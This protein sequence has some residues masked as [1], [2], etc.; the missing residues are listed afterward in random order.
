MRVNPPSWL[1]LL[2]GPTRQSL[3]LSLIPQSRQCGTTTLRRQPKGSS[4]LARL[5][6]F[7]MLFIAQTEPSRRALPS[8][9]GNWSSPMRFT[10]RVEK[11]TTAFRH[12][13]HDCEAK[14]NGG[15]LFNSCPSS[16]SGVFADRACAN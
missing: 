11:A 4:P 8:K 12:R 14:Q 5:E 16:P 15:R 1:S 9:L 7:C 13:K 6:L 10:A 3:F 2:E